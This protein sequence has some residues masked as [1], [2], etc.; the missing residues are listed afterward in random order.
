MIRAVIS[1]FGGVLTTPLIEAFLA[2]QEESG[3]DFGS[4]GEAMS[5]IVE[6][7][8]VWGRVGGAAV[9]AE[10]ARR[11]TRTQNGVP[12]DYVE[13]TAHEVDT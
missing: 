5:R 13:G 10:Q 1:D 9:R 6:R 4:L 2:F 8:T 3:V 11:E 7:G 12:G